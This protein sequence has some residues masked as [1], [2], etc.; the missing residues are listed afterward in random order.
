M[1]ENRMTGGVSSRVEEDL[2]LTCG[3]TTGSATSSIHAKAEASLRGNPK[4]SVQQGL[5][6]S[7][8]TVHLTP[9]LLSLQSS[10]GRPT[11]SPEVRAGGTNT[12]ESASTDE[13]LL[14]QRLRFQN[15]ACVVDLLC[16]FALR[17]Y[18]LRCRLPS[19]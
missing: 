17:A 9:E 8:A 12:P 4:S 6:Q 5:W 16:V 2:A 11:N 19:N 14:D 10:E 1:A 15:G 7:H 13:V 3:S 18:L